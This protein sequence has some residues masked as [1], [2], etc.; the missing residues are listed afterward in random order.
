MFRWLREGSV[1]S[2]TLYLSANRTLNNLEF[3]GQKREEREIVIMTKRE[4]RMKGEK[5][6]C[7]T[8]G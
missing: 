5:R 7:H 8:S 6:L 2:P 1:V 4:E 3:E